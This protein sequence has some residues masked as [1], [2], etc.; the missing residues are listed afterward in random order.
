[1]QSPGHA[2]CLGVDDAF[3]TDD[4]LCSCN[5]N[6]RLFLETDVLKR[7]KYYTAFSENKI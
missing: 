7:S 4:W 1:M 5:W 2:G 3:G 6:I